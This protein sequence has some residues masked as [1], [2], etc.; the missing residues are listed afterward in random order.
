MTSIASWTVSWPYPKLFFGSYYTLAINKVGTD[1]HL[2]ELEN[3]GVWDAIDVA[4]LGPASE[5]DLIDFVDFGK[6]Y[7]IAISGTSGGEFYADGF[8]RRP[9]LSTEF[10]V[11]EDL[12]QDR[13]P[14]FTTGCNFNGQIVVGGLFAA[15]ERWGSLGRCSVAWSG[16]GRLEF[17]PDEYRTAGFRHMPWDDQG[18]GRIYSV[19]KLGDKVFVLSNNGRGA[20]IPFAQEFA[21]GFGFQALPGPGIS[22]GNHIA[23]D[24]VLCGFVDTDNDFWLFDADLKGE[25]LGYREYIEQL[26]DPFVVNYVPQKERF[27]LSDGTKS[28]V[29]TKYGLYRCHQAVTSVGFYRGSVLCGFFSDNGNYSAE[30]VTHDIDNGA[31]GIKLVQ[32]LQIGVNAPTDIT[33]AV[34]WKI[35]QSATFRRSNYIRVN[36]QG[37]AFPI[38][39]A[40]DYRAVV[41]LSDYRALSTDFILDYIAVSTQLSDKRYT[42]GPHAYQVNR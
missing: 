19:R 42:R 6:F 26:S 11:I 41:K 2:Y 20:L 36:P 17:R 18:N 8:L 25:R 5:I 16:I 30:V 13:C 35:N 39:S 28:F 27:Y 1:L 4:T 34:D 23:G 40:L 14:R 38:V 9:D 24:D 29:L 7:L 22:S 21:T 33:V 37:F 15:D 3:N 32:S 31:R 12:P 10:D